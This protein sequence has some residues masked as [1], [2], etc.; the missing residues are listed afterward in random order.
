MKVRTLP[1]GSVTVPL[2]KPPFRLSEPGTSCGWSLRLISSRLTRTGAPMGTA[3]SSGSTRSSSAS[4]STC[5]S[6]GVIGGVNGDAVPN[7]VPP[8]RTKMSG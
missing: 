5:R 2:T 1:V 4:T 8:G 6:V 3:S 7:A